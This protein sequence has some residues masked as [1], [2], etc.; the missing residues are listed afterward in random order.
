MQ[1]D[2]KYIHQYI[3]N[4]ISSFEEFENQII[5][6]IDNYGAYKYLYQK[7][8]DVIKEYGIRD[9]Q[10]LFTSLY[11]TQRLKVYNDLE[12]ILKLESGVRYFQ[13]FIN[14]ILKRNYIDIDELHYEEREQVKNFSN[15]MGNGKLGFGKN[16]MSQIAHFCKPNK[17]ALSNTKSQV[18]IHYFYQVDVENNYYEFCKYADIIVDKI[19]KCVEETFNISLELVFREYKYVILDDFVEFVY[20]KINY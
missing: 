13:G 1:T 10:R 17:Y 19:R 6:R 2:L 20:E 15:L 9:F 7:T 4:Q 5:T 18:A 8:S 3:D 12:S 11:S 14:K 16:T